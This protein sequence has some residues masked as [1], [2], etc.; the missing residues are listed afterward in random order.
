MIIAR[1]EALIAEK[2]MDEALKRA[3]AYE[4]AGANAILI[5]SKKIHP[6]KFSNL[7]INGKEKFHW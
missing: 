6:M 4:N 3:N 7:Q 2:G 1:T 5:H